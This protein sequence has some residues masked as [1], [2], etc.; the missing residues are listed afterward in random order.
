[1][2]E[3]IEENAPKSGADIYLTID[4]GLQKTALDAMDG[5]R[6]AVVAIDPNNGDI[7]TLL[8]SPVFDGNGFSQGL[9]QKAFDALLDNNDKPLLNRALAGSYPPGSTIKPMLGLA[10]LELGKVSHEHTS[11]CPGFFKLP[12]NERPY[13]DWKREGHGRVNL[14]ES[15]EQSCDI[16][17]YELALELGIEN[18]HNFLKQ[19]QL[20]SPIN[21]GIEG[22]KRGV[23]PNKAWKRRNFRNAADQVWFPGETVIAGI[24]QGYMLTTPLQLATATA[25]MAKRGEYNPPHLLQQLETD[26]DISTEREQTIKQQLQPEQS[27]A[28]TAKNY[29]WNEVI[30]GM[31]AVVN[32]KQG[33]ARGIKRQIDFTMAGKSGTAQ[34]FTLGEDQEYDEEELEERLRD[35]ALFIAFAPVKEP[36]IAVAVIVENGGG[37]SSTAAPVAT[38]V[39]KAYMQNL[40]LSKP[41]ETAP[42]TSAKL[43]SQ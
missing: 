42:T 14:N 13:R 33:T 16:Y 21:P 7:L 23:L 4:A 35:H 15:I 34:V 26:S 1:M 8:S 39:I 29:N 24:G 41:S 9:S 36:K 25:I 30:N 6:G 5:R 27:I 40:G 20:G 17:F 10:G 32:G 31:H 12:N 18:M 22:S 28:L 2:I 37:G 43:E 19:F 11:Y 38:E 3:V